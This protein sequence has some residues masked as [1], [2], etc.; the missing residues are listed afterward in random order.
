MT[1]VD[2][3][4]ANQN[5][6]AGLEPGVSCSDVKVILMLILITQFSYGGRGNIR[7]EPGAYSG[8][9]ERLRR[10]WSICFGSGRASSSNIG[11]CC[12]R[13]C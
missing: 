2:S 12:G 7:R 8:M 13:R 1:E 5:I 11:I 3:L 9:G 10:F 6:S 4:S